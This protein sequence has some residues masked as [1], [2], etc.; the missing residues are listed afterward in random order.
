MREPDLYGSFNGQTWKGFFT[1]ITTGNYTFRASS[2]DFYYW[3]LATSPRSMVLPQT[4]FISSAFYQRTE[5]FYLSDIPTAENTVYLEAGQ[6]YY[7]EIYQINYGGPSYF[8][9]VVE[10]PN[11]DTT[12]PY[13]TYQIDYLQTNSTDQT[14][15]IGGSFDLTI[16]GVQLKNLPYNVDAL[17]LQAKIREIKGLE[18]T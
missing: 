18:N 16:L 1:A 8:R 10:V 17:T 11:N 4:P 12:L 6:S 3:F 13:Q 9:A 14:T 7:L 5:S 2:D 15:I